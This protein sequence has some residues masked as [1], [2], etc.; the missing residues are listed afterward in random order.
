M[1]PQGCCW[2]LLAMEGSSSGS[3][4]QC[5]PCM[6]KAGAVLELMGLHSFPS[7]S[8]A[9]KGPVLVP[10]SGCLCVTKCSSECGHLPLPAVS[11]NSL[12]ALNCR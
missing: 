9:G 12:S 4:K 11:S 2:L 3:K 10:R 5:L 8:S 7:A 6:R 1:L